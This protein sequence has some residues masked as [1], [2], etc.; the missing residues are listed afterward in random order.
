M[1][2]LPKKIWDRNRFAPRTLHLPTCTVRSSGRGFSHV[3]SNTHLVRSI[4]VIAEH[5]RDAHDPIFHVTPST[6]T[7]PPRKRALLPK[8]KGGVGGTG[9]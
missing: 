4:D 9:E 7:S 6:R 1:Q 2:L 3:T 8:A 5:G